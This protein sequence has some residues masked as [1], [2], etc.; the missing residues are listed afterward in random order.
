MLQALEQYFH[1]KSKLRL[2]RAR[3]NRVYTVYVLGSDR[4]GKG[5]CLIHMF[6]ITSILHLLFTFV[7]YR[8]ALLYFSICLKGFTF[9][10]Y[11]SFL[12]VLVF[13][14]IQL[15]EKYKAKMKELVLKQSSRKNRIVYCNVT[16]F[17]AILRNMYLG[18]IEEC[19]NHNYPIWHT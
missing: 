11:L 4:F 18:M 12:Q 17:I 7:I 9:L 10:I 13:L 3:S 6:S 5:G 2:V 1:Q 19:T 16:L 15:Q 14:Q 8:P